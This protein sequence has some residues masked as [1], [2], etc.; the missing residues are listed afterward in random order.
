MNASLSQVNQ[1][2]ADSSMISTKIDKMMPS[3][4]CTKNPL[5][6]GHISN[7]GLYLGTSTSNL[8]L[9][10]PKNPKLTASY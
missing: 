3:K 1:V 2:A 8:G 4:S 9:V 5:D 7:G 6:T 10:K